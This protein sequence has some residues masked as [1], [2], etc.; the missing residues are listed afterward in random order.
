M[1][2]LVYLVEMASTEGRPT[3]YSP[4]A[5]AKTGHGS[6]GWTLEKDEALGFATGDDA[7]RFINACMPR[8]ATTL[9]PVP[10][11]RRE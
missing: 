9:R 7:Q 8:Q 10:H 5:G 4:E 6:N 1:A 2:K 3:Y 11:T